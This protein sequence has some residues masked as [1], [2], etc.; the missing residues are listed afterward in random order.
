VKQVCGIDWKERI[1]ERMER[2]RGVDAEKDSRENR[3]L[4]GGEG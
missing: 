4:A 1:Y 3:E 2:E